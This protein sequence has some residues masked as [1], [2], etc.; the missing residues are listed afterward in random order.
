[1]LIPV[2]DGIILSASDELN[3]T[4]DGKAELHRG[5]ERPSDDM[6]YEYT[7]PWQVNLM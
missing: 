5:Y 6:E 4:E 2:R 3:K 1:M 7:L